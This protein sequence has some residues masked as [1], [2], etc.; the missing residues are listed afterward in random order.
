M[1]KASSGAVYRRVKSAPHFAPSPVVTVPF[2]WTDN[3]NSTATVAGNTDIAAM[4][5]ID[6]GTAPG[7]YTASALAY[8]TPPTLYS[9]TAPSIAVPDAES[10][11]TETHPPYWIAEH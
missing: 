11:I 1:F 2:V 4:F 3:G 5:G 10:G 9:G 6:Y 8:S 7:V